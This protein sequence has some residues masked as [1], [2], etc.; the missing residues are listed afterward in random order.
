MNKKTDERTGKVEFWVKLRRV[1]PLPKGPCLPAF[2]PQRFSSYE[3][4][5]VWKRER[6]LTLA[7]SNQ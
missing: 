5:N 3:A 6:I 2:T 4:F 1:A 7:E